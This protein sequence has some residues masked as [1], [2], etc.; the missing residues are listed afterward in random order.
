[1]PLPRPGT[2]GWRVCLRSRALRGCLVKPYSWSTT[3]RPV[4]PQE[5]RI[6]QGLF[7]RFTEA[8]QRCRRPVV[9]L[10]GVT[11]AQKLQT[12]VLA[13]CRR[14]WSTPVQCE[15]AARG[16]Y[17]DLPSPGKESGR[18]LGPTR[19]RRRSIPSGVFL[20]ACLFT[21]RPLLRQQDPVRPGWRPRSFGLGRPD[22][23]LVRS[24]GSCRRRHQRDGDTATTWGAVVWRV[25]TTQPCDVWWAVVR[26]RHT[27]HL[28]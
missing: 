13:E 20:W 12:M 1:M 10:K 17:L 6:V 2:T 23:I 5:R 22:L 26:Q 7:A 4:A 3:S 11:S 14:T 27:V 28:R 8:H 9:A 19:T 25:C 16:V 15:L 18:S 24:S 21:E